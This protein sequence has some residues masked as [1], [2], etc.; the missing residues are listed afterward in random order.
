V[1]GVFRIS[2][3]V[4]TTDSA[5]NKSAWDY[6][7]GWTDG[8]KSRASGFSAVSRNADTWAAYVVQDVAGQPLLYQT[9]SAGNVGEMA[10]NLF[11]TVEQLQ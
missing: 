5:S 2:T 3:Y 11:I 7:F 4:T 6:E 9:K 8:I 1:S 10:Y